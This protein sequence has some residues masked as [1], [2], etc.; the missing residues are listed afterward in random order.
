MRNIIY[1]FSML[2]LMKDIGGI[3]DIYHAKMARLLP[4]GDKVVTTL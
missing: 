1:Y 2:S 3:L 4:S